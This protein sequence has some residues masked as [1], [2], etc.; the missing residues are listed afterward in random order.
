MDRYNTAFCHLNFENLAYAA[1]VSCL[2]GRGFSSLWGPMIQ[3]LF[4]LK[5][6]GATF[7]IICLVQIPVNMLSA[8]MLAYNRANDDFS[9]MSY[10]FIGLS[11][12]IFML[13]FVMWS[14]KRKVAIE[15][16]NKASITGKPED[17]TSF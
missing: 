9:T 12:I 1:V 4:P 14:F 2:C 15:I 13:P 3:L 10:V 8:P 6:F 11:S 7:G 5:F 17:T 16:G